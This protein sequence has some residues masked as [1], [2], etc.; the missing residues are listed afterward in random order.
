MP[1]SEPVAI[2]TA[3]SQGIGGGIARVLAERGYRVSLMA[4]SQPILSVAAELGGIAVQGSVQNAADIERVVQ[5]TME[6][7]G[8]IDAVVNNTGHP[9]K[10]DPLD[11]KSVV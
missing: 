1:E 8:R 5:H 11:R 3:S 10:G 9:P 6:V 2:V 4:R 7:Y